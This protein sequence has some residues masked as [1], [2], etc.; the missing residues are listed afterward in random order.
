MPAQVVAADTGG[1]SSSHPRILVSRIQTKS[2]SS[3]NIILA[4]DF[5]WCLF[6]TIKVQSSTLS[7]MQNHSCSQSMTITFSD[8]ES[9]E[10][11]RK[12]LSLL[13]QKVLIKPTSLRYCWLCLKYKTKE[14]WVSR[15]SDTYD[16]FS[17]LLPSNSDLFLSSFILYVLTFNVIHPLSW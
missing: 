13:F 8:S 1:M 6:W 15:K 17:Y 12:K 11:W 4:L 2:S 9:T 3:L 7:L 5:Y 14:T 16:V 10:N